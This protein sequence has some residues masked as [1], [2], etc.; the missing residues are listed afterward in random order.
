M[1]AIDRIELFI[2]KCAVIESSVISLK[3][4]LEDRLDNPSNDDFVDLDISK[5]IKQ[6]ELDNQKQ[7]TRM[8]RYYRIFYMLEN[9]IRSLIADTLEATHGTQWWN[10][11]IP[12]SVQ[13]EAKKNRDREENAGITSRSDVEIDYITFGQLGDIIKANWN[14][15]AGIMTN[16]SAVIR[17]LS[18]LNMLRGT[19]A[20]CGVLADDE[21]DR[22]KLA[23]KDWFRVL[24]GPKS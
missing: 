1:S 23:I 15:F 24:Q 8:A 12:Q 10:K 9:D 19:I 3:T 11:T 17:V 5:Y 18:A 16:Q 20:H 2:L 4:Y 6:F 22:L 7:A 21:V 14:D 13:E